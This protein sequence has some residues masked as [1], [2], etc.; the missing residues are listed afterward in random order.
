MGQALRRGPL[1]RKMYRKNRLVNTFAVLRL[2][3]VKPYPLATIRVQAFGQIAETQ[4]ATDGFFRIEIP[5]PAPPVPGWYVVQAELLAGS[6]VVAQDEGRVIVPHSTRLA[7]IS[8]IDD[9]FLI[10]HS[11]TILKR[12]TVLLTENAHSRK[13]FDGVV[14]HYQMLATL[15]TTPDKP[16]PF[17]YVSSSEWNL[18]EYILE[19]ARKNELPE[20]VYLLNQIKRLYELVKTGKGKHLTK[21]MR[22][23][24]ILENYPDQQFILLGDD[25][26]QD[27][28]IYA[29]VV[30]HFPKQ[31]RAVY[32]RQVRPENQEKTR[33]FLSRIEAAGVLACYFAHSAEARQHTQ[34]FLQ[35]TDS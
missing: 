3:M 10:S 15:D 21:F 31:I 27:P 19:F 32:I 26:Q 4:T 1:P 33:G 13:P 8:D 7:C 29:S 24:R 14:A 20:G 17:F 9:T 28:E 35:P 25:T 11:A 2:F 34:D 16:N 18:Y 6:S 30:E 22:V 23:T 5:L 12:L